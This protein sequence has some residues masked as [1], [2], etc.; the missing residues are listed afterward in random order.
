MVLYLSYYVASF[1]VYFVFHLCKIDGFNNGFQPPAPEVNVIEE[2][3]IPNIF[4]V[5]EIQNIL[6]G[7][8]VEF[9]PD[10]AAAA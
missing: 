8:E 9:H 3:E 7:L 2:L 5:L 1:Y 4:E 10:V 6:A